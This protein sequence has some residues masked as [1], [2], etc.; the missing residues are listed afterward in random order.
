MKVDLT[1]PKTRK[2]YVRTNMNYLLGNLENVL[3]DILKNNNIG[4]YKKKN[5]EIKTILENTCKS[6]NGQLN[7]FIDNIQSISDNLNE[8]FYYSDYDGLEDWS[9]LEDKFTYVINE[10]LDNACIIKPSWLEKI[11]INL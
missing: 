7:I 11:G 8:L 1:A 5:D 10:R 6:L 2:E 9:Q 4:I 3:K